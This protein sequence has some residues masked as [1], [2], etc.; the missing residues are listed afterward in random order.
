[1]KYT[2]IICSLI[3]ITSTQ[4]SLV[5]FKLPKF[6]EISSIFKPYKAEKIIEKEYP[7]SKIDSLKINNIK[8]N[9]TIPSEWEQPIVRVKATVKAAKEEELAQITINHS[10][11][12]NSMILAT[13]APEK[14][15]HEVHY[16]L[17]VPKKLKLEIATN[18]GDVTVAE[19][20]GIVHA[21]TYKGNINI[22]HSKHAINAQTACRG[23]IIIRDAQG[24]VQ[25]YAK[26]GNITIENARNSI[27]A[28]TENGIVKTAHNLIPNT[29]NIKLGTE[30]GNIVVALP[31]S[32]NAHVMA[33]T[34]HGAIRSDHY[35]TLKSQTT[36]LDP[37][38]WSRLKKE[39]DATLGTGDASIQLHCKNGTIHLLDNSVTS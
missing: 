10:L 7:V 3:V 19:A 17:I 21:Q 14:C 4:H 32:T 37:K 30:Y 27:Y 2:S 16:E 38:N 8:G 11:S 28:H 33:K 31:S 9:V 23:N 1:M 25:T 15:S 26:K 6:K 20:S 5:C 18:N 34:D 39:V 35:L 29:S 12:K 24:S 13:N 22:D 36:K